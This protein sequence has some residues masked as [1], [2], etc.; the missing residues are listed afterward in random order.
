M[1]LDTA[2][3]REDIARYLDA[4]YDVDLDQIPPDA[5]L[6]DVGIDSL[7]VL[8]IADL[9]E[10]KYQISLDDERIAAVRTFPDL[11]ALIKVKSAEM[12]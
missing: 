3:I 5:T 10:N 4:H 8:A 2:A 6:G 9:I 1:S 12:A 11:M 7:G